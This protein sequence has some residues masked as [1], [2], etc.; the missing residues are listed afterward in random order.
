[1]LRHH[2]V[3]QRLPERAALQQHRLPL[4]ACGGC[5]AG[6]LHLLSA[7]MGCTRL[8]S[9][10]QC[11]NAQCAGQLTGVRT[12]AMDEDSYTKEQTKSAKFVS[13]VHAVS[14]ATPA[15]KAAAAAA[16]NAMAPP[17]L[18]SAAST[19][20]CE[21]TDGEPDQP[22]ASHQVRCPPLLLLIRAAATPAAGLR[23]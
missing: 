13:L 9:R 4:P 15:A 14:I 8:H 7:P 17:R 20:M 18:P 21:D 2:Q 5:G 6:T 19:P 1:M 3:L 12:A 23:C 22:Q 16:Q 11:S 10:I